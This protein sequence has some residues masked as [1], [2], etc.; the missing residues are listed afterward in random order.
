M[1][2]IFKLQR[3]C[4]YLFIVIMVVNFIFSLS[5]MTDYDDLFGFELEA[6]K[7]I[8]IFH[9][10]M[11]AFNKVIF[12]LSLVGAIAIAVVFILELNHKV[13]DS[14][15]MIGIIFKRNFSLPIYIRE[16]G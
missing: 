11:Q 10:N 14:Q 5:F 1:K 2:N 3:I 12:Y 4:F 13:P 9:D 7:S 6:N 8:K 15:E 16:E